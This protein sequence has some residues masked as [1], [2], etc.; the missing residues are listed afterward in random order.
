MCFQSGL[1]FME[2]AHRQND[3]RT[4]NSREIT[5]LI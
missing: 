2:L 1:Y 3:R 5:I 4:E